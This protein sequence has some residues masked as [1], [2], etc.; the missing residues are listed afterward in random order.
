MVIFLGGCAASV[1]R[2]F[3]R[4]EANLLVLGKSTFPEI[5]LKFGNPREEKTKTING[6]VVQTKSYA[7]A[8]YRLPIMA[9]RTLEVHFCDNVLVGYE[10]V[11]SFDEDH[12]NFDETKITLLKKGETTLVKV[13]DLLG[14][15]AGMGTFPLLNHPTEKAWIY[16]YGQFFTA[17]GHKQE[18][19]L[20]VSSD[21][22]GVVSDIEL[23]SVKRSLSQPQ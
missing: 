17:S 18:K 13:R 7:H 1:G 15:P 16:S 6:K 2:H 20:I 11:S 5:W 3:V 10:F 21:S 4:P 9:I 8:T 23:T 12:T 14:E 19:R 22:N